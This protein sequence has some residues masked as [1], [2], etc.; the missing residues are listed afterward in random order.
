MG[1]PGPCHGNAE[2][3]S[4]SRRDTVRIVL[5]RLG[6]DRLSDFPGCGRQPGGGQVRFR[7]PGRAG[8]GISAARGSH[9]AAGEPGFGAGRW[10]SGGSGVALS[11]SFDLQGFARS[12]KRGAAHFLRGWAG[13]AGVAGAGGVSSRAE[14]LPALRL[15]QRG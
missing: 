6:G 1:F 10:A 8:R 2:I 11:N 5:S 14:L 4:L 9:R 3:G 12:A 15:D 13:F 7:T